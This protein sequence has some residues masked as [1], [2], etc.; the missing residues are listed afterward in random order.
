MRNCVCNCPSE[1]AC[2][3][4]RGPWSQ[5]WVPLVDV[6]K[7][8]WMEA[9]ALVF[10]YFR[11]RTPRSFVEAREASIVWNYKSADME[12]GRLQAPHPDD[13]RPLLPQR[14]PFRALSFAAVISS[15]VMQQAMWQALCPVLE[16]R[17]HMLF[18]SAGQL[19]QK[20]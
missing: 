16:T 9:V 6:K 20:Y 2:N 19:Y 11:E 8:E 3:Y 13:H 18:A 10:D 12:F 1:S 4:G 17:F 14:T 5:D 15:A 7:K